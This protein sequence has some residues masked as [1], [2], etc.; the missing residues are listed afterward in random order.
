M[1]TLTQDKELISHL[2]Q[3][4]KQRAARFSDSGKMAE[5]YW[6]IFQQAVGREARSG[7][8]RRVS[9]GEHTEFHQ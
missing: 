1:I 2:V 9:A 5:Q 7:R 8:R 3:A 6:E 4:G